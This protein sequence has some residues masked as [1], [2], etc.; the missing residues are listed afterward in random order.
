[1]AQMLTV[2]LLRFL[3][4]GVD[5]DTNTLQDVLW[6]CATNNLILFLPGM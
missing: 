5:D 4:N 2:M 1:M 3:G 6:Y